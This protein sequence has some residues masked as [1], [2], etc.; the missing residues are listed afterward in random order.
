MNSGGMGEKWLCAAARSAGS[1]V[2][3]RVSDMN[4]YAGMRA[5][6][7]RVGCAAAHL[8]RMLYHTTTAQH[9]DAHVTVPYPPWHVC[10]DEGA[11]RGRSSHT[12]VDGLLADVAFF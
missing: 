3:D 2:G 12:I 9:A 6:T 4:V 8:H 1:R 7:A 5:V 10:D 11:M